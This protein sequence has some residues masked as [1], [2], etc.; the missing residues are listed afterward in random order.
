VDDGSARDRVVRVEELLGEI[1]SLPGP[2]GRDKALEMVQALV[3]LY[4]EGLFRIMDALTDEARTALAE[5]ELV[6]H[7]LLVHDLHPRSLEERVLGALAE[8]QPYLDSHGGGVEL[9]GIEDDVVRLRLQGSCSGC[10]SS[11]VT[12]KLAIEDAI[13]KAAPDVA[14]I[15][16]EGVAEPRPQVLQIHLPQAGGPPA[17]SWATAGSLAEVSGGGAVLK[18]VSGESLLFA[19]LGDSI[20]AYRPRCPSCGGELGEAALDGT[21]FECPSCAH[22]YDAMRAGRCLEEPQLNLEPVPLLTTDAG[23]VRVALGAAA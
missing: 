15:V 14:E 21:E 13:H 9:V 11:T 17:D 8:V 16:A 3:E 22:R 12:L 2:A 20:Y 4:G 7:L 10:P 5:D 18:Q 1:E 23:L 6:E 19:R